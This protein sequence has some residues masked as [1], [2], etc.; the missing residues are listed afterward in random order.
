MLLRLDLDGIEHDGVLQVIHEVRY[1][2]P[3]MPAGKADFRCVGGHV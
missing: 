1:F 3:S 2:V